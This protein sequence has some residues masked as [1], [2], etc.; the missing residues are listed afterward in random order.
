ML[1]AEQSVPRHTHEKQPPRRGASTAERAGGPRRRPASGVTDAQ[2]L[3][4]R[5]EGKS[6][7]AIARTLGLDRAKEAHKSY[8]RALGR[9]EGDERR[10]LIKSEEARLDELERRI[11]DRDAADVPK[12]ERRLLG[13]EKLRE[14]IRE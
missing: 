5:E 7:S 11:R 8:V 2:A 13:V 4:L 3:A 9:H 14:A 10:Q 6:F 1:P 12:L